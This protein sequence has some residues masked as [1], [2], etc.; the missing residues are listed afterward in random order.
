MALPGFLGSDA[1]EGLAHVA[2]VRKF[3]AEGGPHL[4]DRVGKAKLEDVAGDCRVGRFGA[5][6]LRLPGLGIAG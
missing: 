3:I 4:Q 5:E 6:V 2:W 1:V